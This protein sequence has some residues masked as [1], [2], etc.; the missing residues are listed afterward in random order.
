MYSEDD[1]LPISALQHLAF[2]ERQWGL[3]YLESIWSDNRLTAEGAALHERTNQPHTEMRDDSHLAYGLRLRSL[4]LGLTGIADLVEFHPLPCEAARSELDSGSTGGVVLPGLEGAWRAKPVE[5]KR[6]HPKPDRCDEV[7]LCA[8]ALCLEEM[9]LLLNRR[10]LSA[11]GHI[12]AP[13]SVEL[14]P[15]GLGIRSG[16]S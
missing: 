11:Q 8:Q 15:T 2:C 13:A 10:L 4:R 1:L 16:R 7:Q 3:I 9:P 5:Y 6:G 12:I 14:P